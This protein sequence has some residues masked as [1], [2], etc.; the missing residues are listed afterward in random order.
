MSAALRWR[1]VTPSNSPKFM[2]KG[3]EL[4]VALA[5]R[6]SRYQI[7]EIRSY[8][9]DGFADRIHYVRDAETVSDSDVREGRR[10]AIV[11]RC[12]TLDEA[13]KFCTEN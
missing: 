4:N 6:N 13:L 10:P 12:E 8:D 2:V 3:T 11:Y 5:G 1:S 7:C 9:K